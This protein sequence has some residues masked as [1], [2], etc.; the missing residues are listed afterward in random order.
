MIT[1]H[2]QRHIASLGNLSLLSHP[3]GGTTLLP[4]KEYISTPFGP[5]SWMLINS[6]NDQVGIC[7]GCP[8]LQRNQNVPLLHLSYKKN[9]L[10][11]L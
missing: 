10:R 5:C 8:F 1:Y 2:C 9:F 7:A 11:A 3:Q 4:Q 6:Y